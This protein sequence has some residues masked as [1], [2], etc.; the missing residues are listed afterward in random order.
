[1]AK[2]VGLGDTIHKLTKYTGVKPIVKKIAPNCG[3]EERRKKLNNPK[4][5][6]NKILYNNAVS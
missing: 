3:C 1:M 4:L 2:S 6:F 5:L